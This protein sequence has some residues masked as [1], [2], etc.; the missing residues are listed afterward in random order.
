M[1]R[2]S[3]AVIVAAASAILIAVAGQ[4]IAVRFDP[5]LDKPL[6][7]VTE[8]IRTDG[9][10]TRRFVNARRVVFRRADAQLRAEVTIEGSEPT[11]PSDDPAAMARAGFAHIA[12]RTIIF[13]LDP[14][15]QVTAVEDHAAVWQA[16]LDGFAAQAPDGSDALDRK[17]AGRVRAIVGALAAMPV[18]RQ[19][20]TLASLV[21]PLIA[22]D[23]A[24]GGGPPR[25]VRVP[26]A[27][28]YGMAEL[29]GIRVS[30]M[31]RGRVELSVTAQ[32]DIA[33]PGSDGAARARVTLETQRVIDPATGLVL[34]SHEKVRT[35]A[36]D[37]S[38]AA[39][40]TS[41]SRLES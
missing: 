19:R 17:R 41:V 4:A 5:P 20:E 26:A 3:D 35:L 16:M 29:Q 6:R 14:T 21:E 10:V 12:G 22:A 1:G 18:D 38:V 31:A 25:P 23:A 2:R 24:G 9:G 11:G 13:R 32:G 33:V 39:E 34:E 15:G 7:V 36:A 40:R 27:S 30:R 37:G 8:S 28:P